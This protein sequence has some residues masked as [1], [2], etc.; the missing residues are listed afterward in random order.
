MALEPKTISLTAE[1]D[2]ELIDMTRRFWISAAFTLPLF[3]YAML[4][5]LPGHPLAGWLT[6]AAGNILQLLLATPVVL[7]GGWPFFQR[8]WFSMVTRNLNM[9]TLIGLGTGV[10]YGYSVIAAL[11]PG[12]FPEAFR[13]PSGTV[14]VYFEA[15]AV[16]V[17]LV[18]LGQMLELKARGRTSLALRALLELAPKQARRV[19]P[20]GSEED[21]PLDGL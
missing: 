8:A 18:L 9:F 14:D 17:T 12:I 7:W 1:P 15:S 5:M 10:A 21:I 4:H 2:P 11:L 6:P 20:D 13:S 3:L 16:I 19:R